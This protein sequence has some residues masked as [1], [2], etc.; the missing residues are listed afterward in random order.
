MKGI[1]FLLT[2][3]CVLVC[4]AM[5]ADWSL[6]VTISSPEINSTDPRV[7]VDSA[8]NAV[9]IWQS[10]NSKYM[11][12]KGAKLAAGSNTWISTSDLSEAGDKVAFSQLAM[13]SSGNAVALWGKKNEEGGML[14]QSASLPFGSRKWNPILDIVVPGYLIS[15]PRL[16]ISASGVAVAVWE[17]LLGGDALVLIQGATLPFGSNAWTPTSD[18]EG[19]SCLLNGLGVDALGNAV[20]VWQSFNTQDPTVRGARLAA[21]S[22]TWMPTSDLANSV[23]SSLQ[24]VVEPSGKATAVWGVVNGINPGIYGATLAIG[25][26]TWVP[27]PA[28]SAEG[29][30]VELAVDSWGNAIALWNRGEDFPL[31]GATLSVG[32]NTWVPTPDV[33]PPGSSRPIVHVDSN[34]NAVAVW[35]M[36]NEDTNILQSSILS[37]KNNVWKPTLNISEN[38]GLSAMAVNGN[39]FIVT[40]WKK[41]DKSHTL[42]QASV[43]YI[44]GP[45]DPLR[46]TVTSQPNKV[47]ANGISS[48]TITV[49]LLD[50][51][52]N[53]IHGKIVSLT[54][55]AGRSVISEP[56]G[57]SNADGI[58]TFTVRNTRIEKVKYSA[59]NVTDGDVIY[60]KAV[61]SFIS[62]RPAPARD[63]RAVVAGQTDLLLWSPSL[64]PTVVGYQIFN[65]RG[66]L[67][68]ETGVKGPFVKAVTPSNSTE[69][70]QY[71]L[72]SFN[73]HG[74]KSE[75][76]IV[77]LP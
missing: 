48:S 63:F 54:A 25:S 74:R 58:V 14:I 51:S 47:E 10:Q 69:P 55:N 11:A 28:L 3:A 73:V 9:A 77:T 29:G 35:T 6:P 76:R 59:T 49:T 57:P 32:N 38:V 60:E 44:A 64:D 50:S 4:N 42:I 31:Q 72:V 39:G 62:E 61:V 26:T 37:I 30:N 15:P 53:P 70:R 7:S 45:V 17:I 16:S 24:I 65:D 71:T 19:G 43:D 13:D 34:G 5:H 20:A 67:V 52:G 21:G 18:L 2:C 56:S 22:S 66:D 41:K 68:V 27:T 46:S 1:M 75:P 40:A 36:K 8:G 12:I 23:L 33:A